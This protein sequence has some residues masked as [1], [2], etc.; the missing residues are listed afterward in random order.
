MKNDFSH[1]LYLYMLKSYYLLHFLRYI[2]YIFFFTIKFSYKKSFFIFII[3]IYTKITLFI[4]IVNLYKV[5]GLSNYLFIFIN[6][7]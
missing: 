3:T 1:L 6:L 4:I 5:I 2:Y 7:L